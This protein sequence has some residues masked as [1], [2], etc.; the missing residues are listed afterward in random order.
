MTTEDDSGVP[1]VAPDDAVPS[2]AQ[3][4]IP[5]LDLP[6]LD[7]PQPDLAGVALTTGRLILK[8]MEPQDIDAVT[9]ICQDPEI[10]RWTL[11]PS[12]YTRADAV[13]FITEISPAGRAAGTDAAF[14]IYHATTGELLGAV[15]LHG[16]KAAD[17]T[18]TAVAEIGYWLAP[19]AR[20]NGYVTEAV[21]AVCRWAFAVLKLHRIEW[22]AFVPN[23]SS[24]QVALRAG[25][26][27]EGTLRA[28]YIQRGQVVDEWF[29]ALLATDQR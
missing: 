1:L 28:K 5:P 18:H 29:G 25:F 9:A 10:Q 6:L 11:V 27:V 7:F 20:G 15:G 12:P 2:A 13:T 8:E 19:A 17:A 23:E 16:I 26:T 21:Q 22:R 3:T 14:G 24:R 4:D